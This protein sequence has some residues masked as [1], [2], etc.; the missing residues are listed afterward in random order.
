M[1]TMV[2]SL[3]SCS[4]LQAT[5]KDSPEKGNYYG[6]G[7]L[8]RVISGIR[9]VGTGDGSSMCR[10]LRVIKCM[11]QQ[12][13]RIRFITGCAHRAVVNRELSNRELRTIVLHIRWRISATSRTLRGQI[14]H[15]HLA[16]RCSIYISPTPVFPRVWLALPGDVRKYCSPRLRH[17]YWRVR[18]ITAL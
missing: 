8:W 7:A 11:Q 10:A 6:I 15:Q 2:R 17:R 12:V 14:V 4:L 3:R 5:R 16:V 1:W 9:T 18:D 13:H